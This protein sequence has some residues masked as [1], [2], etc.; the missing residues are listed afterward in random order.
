MERAE[1]S[2]LLGEERGVTGHWREDGESSL[3]GEE[4]GVTGHWREEGEDDEE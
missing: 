1:E 3:L 4:R 2:S